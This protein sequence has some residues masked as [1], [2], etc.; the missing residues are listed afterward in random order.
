MSRQRKSKRRFFTTSEVARYCGVSTDGVLRWIRARKLR[1]FSTP[2]G[3][4]RI[5]EEDFRVFLEQY[6]IPV[7][8][9]YFGGTPARPRTVLVVDD[10]ESVRETVKALLRELDPG[11]RVHEAADGYQASLRI[12]E[13]RPDLVVLDLMLPQVDG[14]ELLRTLRDNPGTRGVK[15]LAITGGADGRMLRRA[16]DAGAEVCLT[17]PLRLVIFR[18]EVSRLLGLAVAASR[19]DD[20][21]GGA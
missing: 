12:G 16:Y 9:T 19:P 6:G 18:N 15:V 10:E 20:G 21:T 14:I 4:H 7:D 5:S 13:L 11:M 3:H 8:E 17:K 2:G 1:A